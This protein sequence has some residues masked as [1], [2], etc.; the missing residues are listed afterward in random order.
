MLSGV[1]GKIKWLVLYFDGDDVSTWFELLKSLVTSL[2]PKTQFLI[3]CSEQ[4]HF[5]ILWD[6][7]FIWAQGKCV[8]KTE[9]GQLL[10]E[11]KCYL[12]L[13]PQANEFVS[14]WCR[15]PFFFRFE[16][17]NPKTIYFSKTGYA[18]N[19]DFARLNWGQLN[20]PDF[21]IKESDAAQLGKSLYL[22]GGNFLAD[23][24]FILVGYLEFQ[25]TWMPNEDTQSTFLSTLKTEQ[26]ALNTLLLWA[27]GVNKQLFRKVHLLG[28]DVSFPKPSSFL[29]DKV[30][31]HI[32]CYISLTSSHKIDVQG[33][34]KYVLLVA[35][36]EQLFLPRSVPQTDWRDTIS[37]WSNCLDAVA[38]QLEATGDFEILRNPVP[39]FALCYWDLDEA[40]P[41]LLRP[42]LG[43]MNNVLTEI[44]PSTKKVWLPALK[45]AL[46]L[47]DANEALA[48]IEQD[49]IR[50]WAALGF[51]VR[52]IDANF[53][54][55]WKWLGG[56]RCLTNHF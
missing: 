43:L 46:Y 35:R 56:I 22:S 19:N 26:L 39:V 21:Q 48:K 2:P 54:P 27:N 50:L 4:E 1:R 20:F 36:I 52:V 10:Q 15:D 49:N 17:S 42:Y 31:G 13:V 30:F 5:D 47:T 37:A 23:E 34:K 11:A 14:I 40:H 24:D 32:D 55:F 16:A 44:T 41:R 18:P 8:K 29:G 25:R 12:H 6:N 28:K 33:K 9:I 53:H 7:S 3:C 45:P 38:Q 51:E